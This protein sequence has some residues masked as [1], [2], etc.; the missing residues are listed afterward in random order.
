M[1]SMNMLKALEYLDEDVILEAGMERPRGRRLLSRPALIAAILAVLL[2]I[3]TACAAMGGTEWF[4]RYFSEAAPGELS[5][6]QV[7]YIV[8]N[9][10]NVNKSQTVNGYTFT[11]KSAFSDGRDILLQFDL[12]APK[13]TVLDAD[14]YGDMYG[15]V[16]EYEAGMPIGISMS[17]KM[18]D[19]DRTDNRV[20]LIYSINAA[21]DDRASEKFV[22]RDCRLYIYGIEARWFEPQEV[23]TEP[24]TEGC[25]TFDIHFPEECN[26]MIAFVQEPV[27]VLSTIVMGYEPV[28]ENQMQ[29]ITQEVDVEITALNLRALGAELAFRYGEE[30]RNGEF[31]ELYVVMK[32][33]EKILLKDNAISPNFNTYKVETPL[34]LE[35]VDHILFP[36]GTKFYVS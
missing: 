23:R 9:T 5:T 6:E 14:Y 33:G 12:T 20:S 21:W 4:L 2:L 32:N 8:A 28:S 11:L 24:L 19:E 1:T 7:E 35:N 36:D 16:L 18:T 25:W 26:K 30:E 15:T 34:I 29:Q 27:T 3:I 10:V 17:W 31:G 22:G 13:G